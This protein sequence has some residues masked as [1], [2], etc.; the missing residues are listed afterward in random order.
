MKSKEALQDTSCRNVCWVTLRK[1]SESLTDIRKNLPSTVD[2][3]L[4]DKAIDD[5][6]SLQRQ[7]KFKKKLLKNGRVSEDR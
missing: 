5:A 6:I 7:R 2:I 1:R 3:S 4:S